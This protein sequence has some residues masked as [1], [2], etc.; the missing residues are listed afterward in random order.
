MN[1]AHNFFQ[2][3]SEIFAKFLDDNRHF[4]SCLSRDVK[5]IL[6]LY[7][8]SFLSKEGEVILDKAREFSFTHLKEIVNKKSGEEDE[9]SLMVSKSLGLPLNWMISRLETL[10][11]IP[12]YE[13]RLNKSSTLLELA[14][15]DYNIVQ[16]TH[17]EDIKHLSR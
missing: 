15:L 8:A 14:K 12:V 1:Y 13:R 10:W 3:F 7:E 2:L 9:L 5:C 17:Q 16:A 11:F 4:H 6:Y